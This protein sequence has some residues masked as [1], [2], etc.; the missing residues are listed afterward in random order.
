[1]T[2]NKYEQE[3]TVIGNRMDDFV[4][5]YSANPAHLRKMR[6]DDRFTE[7]QTDPD[8]ESAS[9][10]ISVKDF[11]PMTGLRRRRK[12]MSPEK[13]AA[14]AAQMASMRESRGQS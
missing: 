5:I 3:T 12:E 8:G 11:N 9:F 14:L 10:S 6:N 13:R 2:L 1:M 4:Q 7:I